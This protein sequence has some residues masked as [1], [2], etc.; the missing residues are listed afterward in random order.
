MH[1][2]HV[3]RRHRRL[4][5]R[6]QHR[7]RNQPHARRAERRRLEQR[8]GGRVVR[9]ARRQRQQR[10]VLRLRQTARGLQHHGQRQVG[11]RLQVAGG[12]GVHGGE[13]VQDEVL[14]QTHHQVHRPAVRER[15]LQRVLALL[16]EELEQPAGVLLLV[17]RGEL[18]LQLQQLG[19]QRQVGEL[20]REGGIYAQRRSPRPTLGDDVE[21]RAL[22]QP[23]AEALA[24]H[25]RGELA[26][27]DGVLGERVHLGH[28]HVAANRLHLVD[29]AHLLGQ[30]LVAD[31]TSGAAPAPTRQ[32]VAEQHPAI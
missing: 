30:Q 31:Y 11:E 1:L 12:E 7:S 14:R 8:D 25:V 3:L 20:V 32:N 28:E 26:A 16:E 17:E 6:G 21:L 23:A 27:G 24:P 19:G 2:T 22:E 5:V 15:V 4:R 10:T 29:D 18:L 9:R 13:G